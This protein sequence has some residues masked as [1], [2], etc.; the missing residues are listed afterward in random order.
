MAPCPPAPRPP[1]S[2]PREGWDLPL[3]QVL[4]QLREISHRLKLPLEY[5]C[6]SLELSALHHA[7]ARVA[8][9]AAS[10]GRGAAGGP[11]EHQQAQAQAA[12]EAQVQAQAAASSLA[13]AALG[14][15]LRGTPDFKMGI[16]KVAMD[17]WAG[18]S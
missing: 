9:A 4:T 13:R 16:M 3:I 2:P 7:L 8:V 15:L 1:T 18:L 6:Y 17:R 5:V 12:A 14:P 11:G 10:G